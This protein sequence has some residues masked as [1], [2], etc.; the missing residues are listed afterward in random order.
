MAP[1]RPARLQQEGSREGLRESGGT[2]KR[3]PPSHFAVWSSS[4]S[5]RQPF[6][7]LVLCPSLQPHSAHRGPILPPSA[8][9]RK[10]S[11][12]MLLSCGHPSLSI[13][14]LITPISS[15]CSSS[16]QGSTCFLKLLSPCYPKVPSWLSA[17]ETWVTMSPYSTLLR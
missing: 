13:Q 6:T 17:S 1:W 4:I 14:V 2:R 12:S 7:L 15:L 11:A 16:L 9:T 10:L 8:P 3:L 5:G